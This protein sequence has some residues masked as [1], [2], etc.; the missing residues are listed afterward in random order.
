MDSPSPR[1]LLV[2]IKSHTGLSEVALAKLLDVSQPTVNRI[3]TSQP[4]CSSKSLMAIQHA[5]REMKSG[6]LPAAEQV[7]A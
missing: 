2:E 1:D 7:A 3:L 4:G 6:K 5:H